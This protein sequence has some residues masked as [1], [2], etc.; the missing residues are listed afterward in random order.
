MNKTRSA[1]KNDRHCRCPR[2]VA[3]G[4]YLGV[5]NCRNCEKP[6]APATAETM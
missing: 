6:I 5:T 3:G 1:M 4:T 2:P